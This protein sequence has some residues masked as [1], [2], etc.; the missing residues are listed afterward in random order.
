ME[1][2]SRDV[3]GYAKMPDTVE[4]ISAML[5]EG[6]FNIRLLVRV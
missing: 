6:M 5:F 1:A 4:M 3:L 2:T